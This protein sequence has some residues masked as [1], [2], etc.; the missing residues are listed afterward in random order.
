[1]KRLA[2]RSKFQKAKIRDF[3][4]LAKIVK[5]LA[6]EIKRLTKRKD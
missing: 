4:R 3:K 5:R 2:K 1:M 6:N